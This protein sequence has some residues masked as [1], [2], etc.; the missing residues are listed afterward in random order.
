VCICGDDAHPRLPF[1]RTASVFSFRIE[2]RYDCRSHIF[3]RTAESKEINIRLH[4]GSVV[5]CASANLRSANNFI[6]YEIFLAFIITIM[7]VQQQFA[8]SAKCRTRRF[9][10]LGYLLSSSHTFPSFS[11]IHCPS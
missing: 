7:G 11:Q 8:V 4:C 6:I 2:F 10:Q 5:C 1:L 3:G 9:Q